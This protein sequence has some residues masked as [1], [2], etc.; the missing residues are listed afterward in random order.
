VG[1]SLPSIE[2][3]LSEG[4]A[5]LE[6]IQAALDRDDAGTPLQ[7][8]R[9]LA[10]LT[11]PGKFL[12]IA[13]NYQSHL[14]DVG[15]GQVPPP[16]SDQFWFTKQATCI[17]G[18]ND[19]IIL[20]LQSA[21][22]DYEAEL[23][24]VI[25][26]RCRRVATDDAISM[27]AGYLVCNDVSVRDWQRKAPTLG[28]SFDSHGPIG[29][30]ITT[31]DEVPDPHNLRLRSWVDGEIRQDSNTKFMINRIEAMIEYLS[32][33]FTLEPGDILSTGTPAGVGSRMNPPRYLQP[34]QKVKVHIEGLGY[35]ENGVAAESAD[36]SSDIR[37]NPGST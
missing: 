15:G 23:G 29:P 26:K 12:G 17:T 33:V 35:L 28:K 11:R 34:G 9:L 22:V 30:W 14:E 20:P 6:R 31:A 32:S 3:I 10:P 13:H 37:A 27:V 2:A 36:G 5:A 8:V 7:E 1:G 4:D 24:I 16:S 21:E 18:P 19:P 25:G